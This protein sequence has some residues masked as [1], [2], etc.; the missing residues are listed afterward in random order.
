MEESAIYEANALVEQ[1]LN[2]C[3]D[4]I[5]KYLNSDVLVFSGPIYSGADV[6]IRDAVE[7]RKQQRPKRAKLSFFLETSGGY[8]EIA[9]RIATI[10]RKHY[11]VVEFY[12]PNAAMSAGTVLVM[13]GN[14]IHMD[15]FSTLGPIDPQLPKPD[16]SSVPALGYLKKFEE[17]MEKANDG[18]LNTA[19][20][21]YLCTKFD[22][23]MLYQYEH[24]RQL[25]V[26]LIGEWLAKYK[27][28]NWKKTKTKRKTVTW[29]MKKAR[30]QKI[31]E[32]LNETDIW[33][34]HGHG[35][36]MQVLRSRRIKLLIEDFGKDKIL[37]QKIR[38]YWSLLTDHMQKLSSRGVIHTKDRYKLL[39]W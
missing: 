23:A 19:E 15:Y 25:S 27:F 9:Q 36:S 6:F 28:K 18:E 17:L 35:I 26:Y 38:D 7:Q 24:A 32:T 22:P 3:I 1:K 4:G 8:I 29:A 34:S 21:T 12:I 5:E 13:S 31:A 20:T 16:G 2:D 30:A 10:L 11:R 33:H 14:A 39:R 37:S